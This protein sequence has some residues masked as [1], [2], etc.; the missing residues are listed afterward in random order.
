MFSGLTLLMLAFAS[1]SAKQATTTTATCG[2]GWTPF[3][4]KCYRL[5]AAPLSWTKASAQC[6]AN[7]GHLASVPDRETEDFLVGLA[8][9][10]SGPTGSSCHHG[11]WPGLNFSG[12]TRSLWLGGFREDAGKNGRWEEWQWHDGSP[13][14]YTNWAKVPNNIKGK[15]REHHLELRWDKTRGID[16][17]GHSWSNCW[18]DEH[19]WKDEH[20]PKRSGYFCQNG[21]FPMKQKK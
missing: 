19:C 15:G 11:L 2:A 1:S 18:N 4:E 21:G 8:K 16:K 13:W 9:N 3:K 7:C 10:Y 20:H 12:L 5:F 17:Y 6:A 14:N